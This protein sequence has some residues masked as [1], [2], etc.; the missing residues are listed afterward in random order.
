MGADN[1]CGAH[2]CPFLIP[3]QINGRGPLYECCL[4]RLRVL[5]ES[6]GVLFEEL[7]PSASCYYDQKT[8]KATSC[9]T[10]SPHIGNDVETPISIFCPEMALTWATFNR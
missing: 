1:E 9:D 10:R 5:E 6:G 8:C 3:A 7:E 2:E 4:A